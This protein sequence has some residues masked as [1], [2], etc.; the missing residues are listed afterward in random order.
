MTF[1]EFQKMIN[2]DWKQR[3]NPIDPTRQRKKHLC[4]KCG[5]QGFPVKMDYLGNKH[6]KMEITV[7]DVSFYQCPRCKFKDKEVMRIEGTGQKGINMG[8]NY[9]GE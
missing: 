1:S 8:K 5:K 6:I 7:Y 9:G 4:P 2:T 3:V